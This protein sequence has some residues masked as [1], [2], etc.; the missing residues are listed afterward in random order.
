MQE[1]AL[2][3]NVA[4]R[5]GKS[6]IPWT[7]L[8]QMIYQLPDNE[9]EELGTA[10]ALASLWDATVRKYDPDRT[11]ILNLLQEFSDSD[12]TDGRDRIYALTAPGSNVRATA[13]EPSVVQTYDDLIQLEISYS[14]TTEQV[15]EEFA[16]ACI[17]LG[18]VSIWD[19]L[20][21]TSQ[22]SKGGTVQGKSWVPDWRLPIVRQPLSSQNSDHSTFDPSCGGPNWNFGHGVAI[23]PVSDVSDPIPPHYDVDAVTGWLQNTWAIISGS[24][25][26]QRHPERRGVLLLRFLDVLIAGDSD[27]WDAHVS[28]HLQLHET[29]KASKDILTHSLVWPRPGWAYNEELKFANSIYDNWV[30]CYTSKIFPPDLS[31]EPLYR[32]LWNVVKSRLVFFRLPSTPLGGLIVIGLGPSHTQMDD[33]SVPTA[34]IEDRPVLRSMLLRRKDDVE[35]PVH[36]STLQPRH[37]GLVEL[38]SD[39]RST[40]TATTF[41]FV[42]ECYCSYT[43]AEDPWLDDTPE[44]YIRQ[45]RL[46]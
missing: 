3:A 30:K 14:R 40:L 12:C 43:G 44:L 28:H 19:M 5:C 39:S 18:Q 42:G 11:N 25:H 15:Y 41:Q 37:E 33:I 35:A 36:S 46:E 34:D 27:A 26:V 17:R 10:K 20:R 13:N 23:D 32:V 1:I 8:Q 38:P 29:Y 31:L 7:R 22:R 6:E 24:D 4:V 21:I 45:I 9:Q 16:A 2:N